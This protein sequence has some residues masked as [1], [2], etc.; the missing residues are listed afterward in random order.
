[1]GLPKNAIQR[2]PVLLSRS[3]ENGAP[4]SQVEPMPH[5]SVGP[6][7]DQRRRTCSSRRPTNALLHHCSVFG[8]RD[9]P[10]GSLPLGLLS[11]APAWAVGH[12]S[13]R[14]GSL[15]LSDTGISLAD[16]PRRPRNPHCSAHPRAVVI[17]SCGWP[18]ILSLRS[19]LQ[20]RRTRR[21]HRTG[22][23]STHSPGR[24][25]GRRGMSCFHHPRP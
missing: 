18:P 7:G 22:H 12:P 21:M 6:T 16:H 19:Q 14:P 8:G 1:V 20:A 2:E 25:Q 10:S 24:L 23:G 9:Y 5:P 4:A 15:T 17:A 13:R 3:Q 11:R